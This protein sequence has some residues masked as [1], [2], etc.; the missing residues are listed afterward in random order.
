MTGSRDR[1]G[2]DFTQP[3][4]RCGRFK[5]FTSARTFG[6]SSAIC[7]IS[8]EPS[9]TGAASAAASGAGSIARRNRRWFVWS[10]RADSGVG[11]LESGTGAN[12]SRSDVGRAGGALR[13]SS[14]VLDCGAPLVRYSRRGR[15][16]NSRSLDEGD[17]EREL[18]V[19]SV[20]D[21]KVDSPNR[22]ANR[23]ARKGKT[24]A[25]SRARASASPVPQIVRS[26]APQI[27]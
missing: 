9:T 10:D 15:G 11:T 1:N 5:S 3:G 27:G 23:P 17:F 21:G 16:D 13:V 22:R 4:L 14:S 6:Q 2:I 26:E 19:G 20:L 24:S 8:N 12:R 25:S 18:G 7:S